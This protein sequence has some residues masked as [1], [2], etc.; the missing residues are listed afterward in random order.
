MEIS[1]SIQKNW[2]ETF[3]IMK[4]IVCMS[5]HFDL[6]YIDTLHMYFEIKYH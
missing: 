5:D 6:L 1:L 2:I 3:N 4:I